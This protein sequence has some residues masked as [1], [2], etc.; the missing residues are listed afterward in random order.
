[1]SDFLRRNRQPGNKHAIGQVKDYIR[2]V[3]QRERRE[4]HRLAGV[5]MDGRRFIFVRRVGEG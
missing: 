4:A 1:M 5:A 2:G 3:A